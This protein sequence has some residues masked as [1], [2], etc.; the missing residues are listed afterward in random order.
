MI[1]LNLG[2]DE[3]VNVLTTKK[4]IFFTLFEIVWSR[5]RKAIKTPM[6]KNELI[7][8]EGMKR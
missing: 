3:A 7:Q 5:D 6:K 4:N 1:I 8:F 2:I